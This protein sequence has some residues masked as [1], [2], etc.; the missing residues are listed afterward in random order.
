MSTC[1]LPFIKKS[2]NS[3][4]SY[5]PDDFILATGESHTIREFVELTFKELDIQISWEGSG[6]N[7]IGVLQDTNSETKTIVKIDP[8]YFRPDFHYFIFP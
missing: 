2:I 3:I 7:E 8:I 6:L 5:K 1:S 4:S